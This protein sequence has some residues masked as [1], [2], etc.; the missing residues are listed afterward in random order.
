MHAI[1]TYADCMDFYGN[2]ELSITHQIIRQTK[3]AFNNKNIDMKLA[4][5]VI[6]ISVIYASYLDEQKK[7][8]MCAGCICAQPPWFMCVK[9]VDSFM[10]YLVKGM[11][12]T[13]TQIAWTFMLKVA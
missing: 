11:P 4:I 2:R 5:N 10:C 6:A 12:F 9:A 7:K 1:Y 3:E 13:H 8:L